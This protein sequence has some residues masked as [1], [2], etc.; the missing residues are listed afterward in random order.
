MTD[1]L[2][3]LNE[4][5]YSLLVHPPN[6]SLKKPN[7]FGVRAEKVLGVYD[8]AAYIYDLRMLVDH[9]LNNLTLPPPIHENITV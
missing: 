7:R 8:G 9:R 5:N 1:I 6:P 4:L 3:R 2:N